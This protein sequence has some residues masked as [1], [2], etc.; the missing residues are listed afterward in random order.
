MCVARVTGLSHCQWA[1]PKSAPREGETVVL[2]RK[3]ALSSGFLG[4]TYTN[5]ARL[6]LAGP[7][8]YEVDS[9]HGGFLSLG[10]LSV[11]IQPPDPGAKSPSKKE[12]T[13][14]SDLRDPT[15]SAFALPPL[16]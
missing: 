7:A 10:K 9:V 12:A 3:F 2:G 4:I 6:L 1:N 14:G 5:G 16:S 8:I 13:R 15:F 11:T